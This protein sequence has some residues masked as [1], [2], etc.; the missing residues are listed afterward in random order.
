MF[1]FLCELCRQS[2]TDR[3]KSLRQLRRILSHAVTGTMVYIA[4]QNPHKISAAQPVT[5]E[6]CVEELF[7]RTKWERIGFFEFNRD[8]SILRHKQP[9]GRIPNEL[10]M[11][12]LWEI[13][14]SSYIQCSLMKQNYKPK[15]FTW[16]ENKAQVWGQFAVWLYKRRSMFGRTIPSMASAVPEVVVS[17]DRMITNF[18]SAPQPTDQSTENLS[19][20]HLGD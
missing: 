2:R 18:E 4:D 16:C 15:N 19:Y 10:A 7:H 9:S 14:V 11:S 8:Y 12:G 3:D 20:V 1:R 5:V 17:D 13:K 6:K